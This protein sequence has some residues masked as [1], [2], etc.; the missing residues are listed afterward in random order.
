MGNFNEIAIRLEKLKSNL[1]ILRKLKKFRKDEILK[2]DFMRGALERY[3]QLSAEISMDV[4]EIII[5]E[6]E[7]EAPFFHREIFEIL[8]KEEILS[9][10]L[11]STFSEIAKFRNVLVHDYMKIDFDKMY[12][13]LQNDLGD[14]EKFI[15]AIARYL[16]K[17]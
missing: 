17:K 4:G 3:M 12:S 15:K 1:K 8:G 9:K 10:E 16:K 11:A 7:L 6:E 5:S 14:F 13:Y 2:D